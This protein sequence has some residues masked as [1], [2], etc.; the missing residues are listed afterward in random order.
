[1]KEPQRSQLGSQTMQIPV[2]SFGISPL[3][4]HFVHETLNGV[5]RYVIP[6]HL[7]HVVKE[8]QLIQESVHA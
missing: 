2:V 6:L 8:E 5:L 7:E 3:S 1:M 4:V